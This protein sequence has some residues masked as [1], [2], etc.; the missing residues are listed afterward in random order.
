MHYREVDTPDRQQLEQIILEK[1]AY[2]CSFGMCD[3]QR[4]ENQ[5]KEEDVDE[6]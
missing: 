1:G 4:L 5:K 3:E 6:I 2:R